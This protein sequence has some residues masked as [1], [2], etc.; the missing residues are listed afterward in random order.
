MSIRV[1]LSL[2]ISLVLFLLLSLI[3]AYSVMAMHDRLIDSA[4]IKL[5]SDL[6]LSQSLINSMYPG[7]W[8]ISDDKLYK[9][10]TLINENYQLVDLLGEQ[11]GNTV[12]LFMGDVRVTTNVK[13]A[14]GKRAIGTKSS[15]EVAQTVLK[16]GKPYLGK[17]QVVGTWNQTAYE[18]IRDQSGTI[19]GMLYTGVPNSLY[20][21][22]VNKFAVRIILAG[23]LGLLISII[24][25]NIILHHIIAKPLSSF[26]NFSEAVSRGDLTQEI[27][28]QSRDELGKLAQSF[29]SMA[30]SLKD[31]NGQI[32][33]ASSLISET[34]KALS[35]QA[36]Q[37]TGAANENANTANKISMAV[38]AMAISIK[39]VS[40]QAQE[41]SGQTSDGQEKI[42]VFF[43][44]MQDMDN[45]I[46]MVSGSLNS[47]DQAINR[48]SHFVATINSLSDQINLL[49]LNA[50]IESARA[51]EAGKG[52]AV[53]AEEVRQLAESSAQ[54]AREI[55]QVINEVLHQSAVSVKDMEGSRETVSR[56]NRMLQGLAASFTAIAGLVEGLNQRSRDITEASSQVGGSI[57]NLAATTEEQT[58]AMEEVS[59]S[60]AEL[61]NITGK[62]DEMVSRFKV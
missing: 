59:A 45:S 53:V 33:Q 57:Q 40:A 42:K 10:D 32:S 2:S 16:E 17:A 9:G 55:S 21:E 39:E 24:I 35:S 1:K 41:A 46:T 14:D 29:N 12:T 50:A 58:A 23:I 15:A 54:S 56:G 48:I 5:K 51:G 34:V 27:T 61:K 49:A 26:L 31:L 47:L 19:I 20:D 36:D 37:T 3:G 11:T 25:C 8:N 6:A 28:Y 4:Q 43:E 18:P 30:R 62:M 22:T 7:Q 44:T 38:D 52:F 60:S 13:T